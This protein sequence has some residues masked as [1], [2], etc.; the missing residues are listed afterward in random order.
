M[1]NVVFKKFWKAN[2][3]RL[4]IGGAFVL[5]GTFLYSLNAK[6]SLKICCLNKEVY[7]HLIDTN[8]VFGNETKIAFKTIL[9]GDSCFKIKDLGKYGE[10]LISNGCDPEQEIKSLLAIGKSIK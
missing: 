6:G 9:S 1:S 3:K 8:K 10:Y 2:K 5:T 7:K 4:L